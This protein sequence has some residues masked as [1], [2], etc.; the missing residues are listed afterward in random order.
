MKIL[1]HV[2]TIEFS[3]G[4]VVF[5]CGFGAGFAFALAIWKRSRRRASDAR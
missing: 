4:L 3:L 1:A 5:A 2:T